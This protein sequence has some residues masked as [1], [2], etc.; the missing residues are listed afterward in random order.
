MQ[1]YQHPK[2]AFENKEVKEGN[3]D[4]WTFFFLEFL[5]LYKI[6]LLVPRNIL[7]FAS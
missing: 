3:R 1:Y 5:S 4:K 6:I 7:F 2:K